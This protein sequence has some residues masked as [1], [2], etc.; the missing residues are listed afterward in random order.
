MPIY[1]Y[2]SEDGE[3]ERDLLSTKFLSP[4]EDTEPRTVEIDGEEVTL[5]R[6]KEMP[7]TAEMRMNWRDW[8]PNKAF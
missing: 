3:V 2:R 7:N 8:N 5:H 6:V 1:T 4:E